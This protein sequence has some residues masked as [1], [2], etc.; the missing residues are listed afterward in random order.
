MRAFWVKE[1]CAG[2]GMTCETGDECCSGYC[3]ASGGELT[4]GDKPMGC[5]PEFGKCTT[6]ADCCGGGKVTSCIGGLCS[7]NEGTIF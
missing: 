2:N 5:V 7:R 6:D 1:P 3:N 4:C